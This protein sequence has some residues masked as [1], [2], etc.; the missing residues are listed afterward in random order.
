ML[1][2]LI[3]Y[4]NHFLKRQFQTFF[5]IWMSKYVVVAF[6]NK[7]C[8]W[9]RC[10]FFNN[11]NLKIT[12]KETY[13]LVLCS[14]FISRIIHFCMKSNFRRLAILET[15]KVE[16]QK[17]TWYLGALVLNLTYHSFFE[18]KNKVPL[19]TL[20]YTIRLY[21]FLPFLKTISLFSRIFFRKF[22]H[23]AWLAFKSGLWWRAH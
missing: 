3:L 15:L 13:Y 7:F 2:S 4:I 19:H 23:F 14:Q 12:L 16:S 9:C 22:C 21:I 17:E 10:I 6:N 8:C 11:N 1:C 20:L 5:L 18:Y